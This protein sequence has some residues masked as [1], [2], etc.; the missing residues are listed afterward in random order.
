VREVSAVD[1]ADYCDKIA[2]RTDSS[3]VQRALADYLGHSDP[4]FTLRVYT[5]LL[6][7]S[8]D[9]TRQAVDAAFSSSRVQGVSSYA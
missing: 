7:S 6:P 1:P 4:G 2:T 8:E 3:P 9:W 5:H